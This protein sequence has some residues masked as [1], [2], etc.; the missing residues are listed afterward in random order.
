MLSALHVRHFAII[1]DVTVE[2]GSGMNVLTG[3]TGAGKSILVDALGLALGARASSDSIRVGQQRA[4]I[5]AGF[6][7]DD[8]SPAARWLADMTLDADGDCHL[9]RVISRDGRS[10]AFIN[11]NPVPVQSLKTIGALLV[12]IHGQHE[13]Q[14]LQRNDQQRALLDHRGG[15]HKQLAAVADSHAIWRKAHDAFDA[16]REASEQRDEKLAFLEFQLA[17]L[18]ALNA[19]ADEHGQLVPERD[20][21]ANAGQL[22]ED[23]QSAIT[24]LYDGE[25]TNAQ[26]H[27]A[28]AQRRIQAI[29]AIDPKVADIVALLS[30]AEV[31]VN[32]A[33]E[34]LRR[35]LDDIEA[36]PARQEYVEQRLADL[37]R[38]ARKHHIEPDALP[39]HTDRL[40]QELTALQQADETLDALAA[41]CQKH[42]AALKSTAAKLTRA[43][44]KAAKTF[45]AEV[46]KG[47]QT[48]GMPGGRVEV[49]VEPHDQDAPQRHGQ[50]RVQLLVSA[51]PGQ[52]PKPV[53][54]VAS[55]G[56]LSRISLAI[57]V[58]AGRHD[59][60]GSMIFD[61]VDAGVGGA[62]AEIVG[63]RMREL[64]QSGCQV[65]AVTHLAQVA[66][67][68]NH[69]HKVVKITDGKS[70]HTRIDTLNDKDRVEEI[71][72]MLTGVDITD[73]SRE[74]AREM[75]AL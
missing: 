6:I 69:H 74:H 60:V 64:A 27:L 18:D 26:S 8:D 63:Q 43:R 23:G 57:Q 54:K 21:L 33:A 16:M 48:L 25:P 68:A 61:E 47:M 12:T 53:G 62:V 49:D 9:R 32:E 34:S 42:L 15:L 1:D 10:R 36:D 45:A 55:G 39:A 71:A 67:Q 2:F 28:E 13:H 75:L 3:E 29:H 56:E 70:T 37:Q 20:R 5:D 19:T 50:D 65:L 7:L 38:L 41:D 73:A 24:A 40:R 44:R 4:E 66:G 11:G 35:Y 14:T 30:E 58:A 52:P 46:T 31:S 22:A 59:A 17:E 72:R 51:N